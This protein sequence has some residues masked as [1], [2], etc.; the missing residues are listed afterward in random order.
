[1]FLTIAYLLLCTFIIVVILLQPS[2]DLGMGGSFGGSGGAETYYG[3]NQA[4][5]WEGKLAIMTQ[6]ATAL[7]IILSLVLTMMN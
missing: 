2:K 4:R 1:M 7:F 3:K 6:W 5:T